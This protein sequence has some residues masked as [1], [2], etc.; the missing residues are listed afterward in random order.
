VTANP[1]DHDDDDHVSPL[2]AVWVVIGAVTAISLA[3]IAG[4]MNG[5]D[6]RLRDCTTV[7]RDC[8]Q[9]T[10]EQEYRRMVDAQIAVA[11]CVRESDTPQ[12]I[13]ACIRIELNP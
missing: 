12:G 7:G 1:P 5:L 13:E 8:Y 6:A 2:L 4:N 10:A 3:V 11:K 9:R